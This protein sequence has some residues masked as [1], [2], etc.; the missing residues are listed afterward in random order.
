MVTRID[1]QLTFESLV[2]VLLADVCIGSAGMVGIADVESA[3]VLD[4]GVFSGAGRSS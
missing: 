1:R 4:E 2:D 3:K